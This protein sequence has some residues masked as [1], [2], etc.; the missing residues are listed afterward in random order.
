MAYQNFALELAEL[1]DGRYRIS[2][3]NSPVGETTV[4]TA[5]TLNHDELAHYLAVLSQEKPNST[6]VEETHA[7]RQLGSKLFNFLIKDHTDIHAAY[8]ASLDRAGSSGL[9]FQLSVEKAGHLAELPWEFLRDPQR[10]FLALSRSTPIVRYTRQLSIRPPAPIMYPLRVLVMIAAPVDFPPLNVEEEWRRLQVA[11]SALQQ[12]HLI[13]L[14]RMDDSSLIGLQ[15]QL[16]AEDYQIFHFIGH[17]TYD[18][19]A[20]QGLLALENEDGSGR[21]QLISGAEI[22]RELGEE[23]TIR[24][25]L[26]NS[27]QSARRN[28]KDPFTSAA[29]SIVA[30]GIPAVVA[31]QYPITDQAALAFSDE[32]YR[33]ISELLPIDTAVSEGRR[34]V[35]NRLQNTEWATPVLF[36]RAD[37]G[38][39]FRSAITQQIRRPSPPPP[40]LPSVSIAVPDTPPPGGKHTRINTSAVVVS[41]VVAFGILAV[42]LFAISLL[43]RRLTLA[44]RPTATAALV[45]ENSANLEIANVRSAPSNPA[46]GQTFRLLISIRNSGKADSGPF[47]WTWN[48]SPNLPVAL[49]GTIDNIPAGASK[50]ISL[51]YSYGWWGSYDSLIIVDRD[52][53]VI[54]TDERD[55]LKPATIQLANEAFD[56]DFTLLPDNEVVVPPQEVNS[57]AFSEWNLS[58]QANITTG[59]NCTDTPIVIVSSG[60]QVAL[61]LGS[62]S[63]PSECTLLPLIVNITPIEESV[64]TTNVGAVQASVFAT[65]A[66]Q[67]TL[68]LYADIEGTQ[69]LSESVQDVQAGQ[70]ITL[71]SSTILQQTIRRIELNAPGQKVNLTRLILYPRVS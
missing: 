62:E 30:R 38:I 29:G 32:F 52:S 12:K 22:G 31:M 2:V 11:T 13:R 60:T 24:L 27:C 33:A 25:V 61:T 3:Q 1:P 53:Q 37:N 4:D 7:A 46:P 8:F 59:P 58:F 40:T 43:G 18:E 51:A 5:N 70:E 26:L 49:E 10:D 34:A 41:A 20:Q 56:I 9:R 15:R 55:N 54:E 44:E 28:I 36:M 57:E 42:A 6:R 66:G 69:L 21:S 71:G 16:R 35:A 47:N 50:N 48:A 67:V 39:I 63:T 68:R 65:V 19:P 64:V 45:D 23:N 17:G 14:D